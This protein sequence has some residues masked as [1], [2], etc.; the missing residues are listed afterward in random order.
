MA[1]T[2]FPHA[3]LVEG[4]RFT[5]QVAVPNVVQGLFRR[6]RRAAYAATATDADGLAIGFLNGLRRSYGDGPLWVRVGKDQALLLLGRDAIR[7]GLEGSPDPFAS[8]PEPKRSGMRH[9]QPDALTISRDPQW[10]DRRRFTEKVLDTGRPAHRLADRFAAV[11]TE[12]ARALPRELDWES[13]NGAVRR[14]T[15]RIVLGEAAA[16]D[17][18][19]STMLGEL[20]D[21]SNPPGRGDDG[22]RRRFDSRLTEYV[23]AAERDSLVG[24]FSEAPQSEVTE[25]AR[26]VTH[27]L[28]ALGDTLAINAL[29]CLACSVRPRG[30][31]GAGARGSRLSPGLPA[32]GHAA[33]AYDVDALPGGGERHRVGRGAAGGRDPAVDRQHLQPP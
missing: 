16:E 9:F 21:K 18:T 29:R 13:F 22:L 12:E 10:S 5:A 26:Q 31:A 20:M 23:D 15:R 24:L 1:E 25:P 6:R 32:R 19:L 7:R 2:D 14:A 28:F 27:W 33:V 11:A 17:E 4:L 8:D 30:A 3:S